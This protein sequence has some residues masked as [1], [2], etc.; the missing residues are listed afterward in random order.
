VISSQRDKREKLISNDLRNF[1][2]SGR[3]VIDDQI[4][5][6]KTFHQL[7]SRSDCS[8]FPNSVDAFPKH[9][10]ESL[11]SDKRIIIADDLLLGKEVLTEMG[12][13]I[14]LVVDFE[15]NDYREKIYD[16]LINNKKQRSPRSEWLKRYNFLSL[17]EQWAIEFNRLF[18]TKFQKVFF[19]NHAKR[20]S[21]HFNI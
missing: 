15:S 12:D 10:I 3:L 5:D 19:L 6:E 1:V 2:D 13:D 8:I 4:Y 14:C 20:I 9:I 21:E 17:S 16:Y 11:L 7:M 18:G